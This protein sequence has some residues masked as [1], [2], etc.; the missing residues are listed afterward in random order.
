MIGPTPHCS[1]ESDVYSTSLVVVEMITG[2]CVLDEATRKSIGKPALV[3]Q[4]KVCMY[5][6]VVGVVII[7]VVD[8]ADNDD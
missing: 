6:V 5:V 2:H 1:F 8:N 4:A 3:S 7:I